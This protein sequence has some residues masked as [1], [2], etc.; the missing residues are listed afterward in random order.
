[1]HSEICS[2]LNLAT[3]RLV[4]II[5]VTEFILTCNSDFTGP[6]LWNVIAKSLN[7]KRVA[8]KHAISTDGF[9]SPQVDLLLGD[10]GWVEHTDNGIKCVPL[11]KT[12][13]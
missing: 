7:C 9:R 12:M 5:L 8:R 10:S 6:Q 4:Q 3:L 2:S 13:P 11:V 1:M